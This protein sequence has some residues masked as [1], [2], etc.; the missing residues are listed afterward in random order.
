MLRDGTPCGRRVIATSQGR[1]A[2]LRTRWRRTLCE[3]SSIQ[4]VSSK[5]M[6]VGIT[7][8]RSRN[9]STVLKTRSRRNAGSISSVS[10]VI[11]TSASNGIASSGSQGAKSGMTASIQGFSR[12]PAS[13]GLSASVIPA[14]GRRS[15]RNGK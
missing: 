1:G 13:A 7:S 5:T 2:L 6:S 4:C 12:A 14:S 11:G 8:T 9:S 3:A 15:E 10:G